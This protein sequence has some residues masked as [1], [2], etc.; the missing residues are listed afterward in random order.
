M[1]IRCTLSVSLKSIKYFARKLSELPPLPPYMTKRGPYIE[2][3][4][5][6][7]NKIITIYEFDRSRLAEA[8]ENIFKQSDVLRTI[9]G[10]SLSAR[11]LEESPGDKK[12]DFLGKV[13]K[14]LKTDGGP[15]LPSI[16]AAD[17]ID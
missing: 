8:W 1:L 7:D 13:A 9:P 3:G 17:S 16:L 2:G 12:F 10:F 15:E 5:G 4:E 6:T 11:I 14:I